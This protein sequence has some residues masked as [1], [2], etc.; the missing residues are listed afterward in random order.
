MRALLLAAPL[1]L[2]NTQDADPLPSTIRAMLEEAM[3][4]GSETEV[5]T[6]VK[7]AKAVS[8]EAAHAASQIAAKWSADKNA[9]V[10][11]QLREASFLALMKG[12]AELGGYL[13]A[14]NTENVGLTAQI[15][16]AREGINWRH[17]LRAQADYQK[18][19]NV[20]TRERYLAAYEPNWKLGPRAYVYGAAQYERDRFSGFNDRISISSGLGYTAISRPNMR[21]DLELGPAYRQTHFVDSST[22]SN[23]AGR[24][25]VDFE[26][27]F[28]RSMS[29]RQTASAYVQ[30]A[31]S[32][33]ASKTALSTRVIGPLSAQLSYTIQYESMPPANR[34]NTDTVSRAALVLDF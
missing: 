24:G 23:I 10:E 26:W 34:K 21:L 5:A 3:N 28:L 7:Y 20:I 33:L 27:K 18:S 9:S 14:G 2:A 8:P 6:I 22:E 1:L 31:N 30:A 12:R 13:S 4:S 15:E 25:S 16:L 17:K 19:Q 32:T 29:F 11:K